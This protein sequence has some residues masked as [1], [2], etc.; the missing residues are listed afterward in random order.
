LPL[1]N[2][3][4]GQGLY[5]KNIKCHLCRFLPAVV[6][7]CSLGVIN[8]IDFSAAY[9]PSMEFMDFLLFSYWILRCVCAIMAHVLLALLSLSTVMLPVRASFPSFPS[10]I[11]NWKLP[12]LV[13]Y[14]FGF[15]SSSVYVQKCKGLYTRLFKVWNSLLLIVDWVFRMT[16]SM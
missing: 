13:F 8:I 5:T 3:P 2:H 16:I 10:C 7:S 6:A 15:L 14:D 4:S 12:L 1:K 11:F 9:Y